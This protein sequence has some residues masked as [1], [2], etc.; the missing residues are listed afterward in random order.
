MS[1]RWRSISLLFVNEPDPESGYFTMTERTHK[2]LRVMEA[3][4]ASDGE[5][6]V[7]ELY[8]EYGRRIMHDHE[9]EFDVA[10][11]LVAIGLDSA[12]SEAFEDDKWDPVIRAE[13]AE[14]LA[15]TGEDV[16]TPIIGFDDDEGNRVG[17]FG[18]VISRPLGRE[19]SLKLWDGF[20]IMATVPGFWEV[21]RT[22]TEEPRFGPR[23]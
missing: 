12:R 21:K 4:R 22:R 1:I 19:A 11:A 3:V 10:E 15:L 8:T 20:V 17:L 6:A 18:P 23:P 2:L 7:G 16:G 5:E 13:M 14:G 9:F